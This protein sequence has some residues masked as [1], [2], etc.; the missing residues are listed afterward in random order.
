MKHH[1]NR[2]RFLQTVSCG[3]AALAGAPLA[4]AAEPISGDAVDVLR[5]AMHRAGACCLAWFDPRHDYLPT[6]GYEVAHDT[7]R[8]WD[9]MLRLEA[10]TGFDVPAKLEEAL[11]QMIDIPARK[12]SA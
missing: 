5:E 9:A 7:G 2:R 3:A 10:A 6:G 4:G 1:L 8:W 11:P 12:E